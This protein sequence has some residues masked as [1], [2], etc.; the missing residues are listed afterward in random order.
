M[1]RTSLIP[2]SVYYAL[3][4][5]SGGA[6]HSYIGLYYAHINLG[7][8]EIGILTSVSALVALAAQPLW[9]TISDRAR[10]K[11][12]ILMICLLLSSATIWLMPA[13][14]NLL[15]LLFTTTAVFF[16]FQCAISP[17]SDAITLELAAEEDFSFSRIRTVGSF[18]FAIMAG[19]AGKI[20]DNGISYIFIVFSV[21]IFAAFLLSFFIPKVKGHQSGKSKVNLV[22]LFRD[23]KLVFIYIYVFILSSTLGF[24]QS[25]HA[26]YS[27][28]LG[29]STQLIGIGVMVGSFSQFPFMI[30]FDRIYKK[31]GIVNIILFSGVIYAVRWLL[32]GTVLTPATL[33]VIWALHGFNYIVLYLCLAEYVNSNVIKELKTSGQMMNSIILL[34]ISKVFGGSAGGFLSSAI[35]IGRTV[36]ICSAVSIAAV[37]G[38]LAVVKFSPAFE[39]NIKKQNAEQ[40]A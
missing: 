7:N 25:F 30:F 5:M 6:F 38:F 20:F 3:I 39:S 28:S 18:G 17:L 15:W 36:L 19:I 24:F 8:A 10:Y 12:R 23:K 27:Q 35:G 2:I 34:G 40:T 21:L 26:V 32:F 31:F 1:K 9:G 4:F 16:F 11:N 37:A 33:I 13:S 29:I 22:E 14:G